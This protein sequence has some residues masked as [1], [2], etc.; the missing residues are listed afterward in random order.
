MTDTI[1]YVL[2]RDGVQSQDDTEAVEVYDNKD[3]A[4]DAWKNYVSDEYDSYFVIKAKNWFTDDDE[5]LET[6]VGEDD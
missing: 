2:M 6:I 3:E 1:H 5:W 4:V